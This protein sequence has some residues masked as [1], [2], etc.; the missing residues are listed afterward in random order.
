MRLHVESSEQSSV[1]T[2]HGVVRP[3]WWSAFNTT[4]KATATCS[5]LAQAEVVNLDTRIL[6]QPWG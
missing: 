2:S 3:V 6:L 1:A 4:Y 5:S